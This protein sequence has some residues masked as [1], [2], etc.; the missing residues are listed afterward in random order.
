VTPDVRFVPL[1]NFPTAF[2][3]DMAR[4]R[5]EA[6]GIA[7]LVKG[8]Q[9]GLFG[10]GFQGLTVGGVELHVPSPD[11]DRARRLLDL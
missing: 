10:A 11:V 3:A 7:V 6:D 9:V 1:A 5:L 4:E 2:E 8:Q